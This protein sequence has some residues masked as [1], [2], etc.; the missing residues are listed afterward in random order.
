MKKND[1]LNK[2]AVLRNDAPP[3]AIPLLDYLKNY[4][5]MDKYDGV[6][7]K[8]SSTIQ[9]ELADIVDLEI[10]DITIY[11]VEAGYEVVIN[12]WAPC[13]NMGAIDDEEKG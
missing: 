5:P 13:W 12:Q 3:M 6:I 7:E 11:M 1:Y 10:N 2:L 8:S 4:Y 9:Q